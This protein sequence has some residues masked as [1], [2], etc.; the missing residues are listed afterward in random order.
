M[1]KRNHQQAKKTGIFRWVFGCSVGLL[2]LPAMAAPDSA[3]AHVSGAT[4][5][6]ATDAQARL[7]DRNPD[8]L[9]PGCRMG[10]TKFENLVPGQVHADKKRPPSAGGGSGKS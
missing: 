9:V 7:Q 5:L 10:P 2:S 6:C 3:V 8:W 1:D 4:Y